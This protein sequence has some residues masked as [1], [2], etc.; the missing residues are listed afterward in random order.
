[1][2]NSWSIL[3]AVFCEENICNPMKNT[4]RARAIIT[5]ASAAREYSRSFRSRLDFYHMVTA[6]DNQAFFETSLISMRCYLRQWLA[7]YLLET[8][9][10]DFN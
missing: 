10:R 7:N 9:L 2:N 3:N 8:I 4:L 5:L 1:M 6:Q